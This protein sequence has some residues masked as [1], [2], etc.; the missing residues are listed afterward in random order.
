MSKPELFYEEMF[1]KE[2]PETQAE[3]TDGAVTRESLDSIARSNAEILAEY[4]ADSVKRAVKAKLEE[5]A[6]AGSAPESSSVRP[7]PSSKKDGARRI[8]PFPAFSSIGFAAAACCVIA[9]SFLAVNTMAGGRQSGSDGDSLLAT[10]LK[11]NGPRLFVYLKVDSEA[12]LLAS[13]TRVSSDD[14]IQVSY[15]SGEDRYG[16]I[17]SVDGNGSVYQHFPESGDM[18]A[19]LLEGGE[20]P[21]DYAYKLDNAPRFERF[22]FVSGPEPVSTAW[23]KKALSKAAAKPG[24]DKASL[25]EALTASISDTLPGNEHIANILLRK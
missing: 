23:F 8:L 1:L 10:R 14:M 13:E 25:P 4:P 19:P 5:R 21:L 9:V 7:A 18:T 12:K 24:F 6:A 3:S 16:A 20:T 2:R 15:I 22:F 17:I 11:G